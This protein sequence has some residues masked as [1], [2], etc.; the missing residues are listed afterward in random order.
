[1]QYIDLHSDYLYKIEK[2]GLNTI[3]QSNLNQLSKGNCLLNTYA[4]LFNRRD[5]KDLYSYYNK[6]IAIFKNFLKANSDLIGQVKSYNDIVQNKSNH[7]IS[8][9][10]SLEDCQILCESDNNIQR[11]YDDGVRL[12]GLLWSGENDIGYSYRDPEKP[13]KQ[14]GIELLRKMEDIGII[15][16][17]S[18]LSDKGLDDVIKFAQKP[19]L[20]SHSNTRALTNHHRNLTDEQIK[21]I[22][23]K[24]GI[25][26]INFYARY[27]DLKRI[28]EKSESKLSYI[29]SH[30][31][32]MINVGGGE[33]VAIGADF[34][35]VPIDSIFYS[36]IK[37]ASFMN[38][39]AERLVTEFGYELA[40]KILYKNA[41]N[42][43]KANLK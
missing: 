30:I 42:F 32:Q 2:N 20:A 27:I 4:I 41:L 40:E 18:H 22:G 24:G 3:F 37:D 5:I 35:G 31:H 6:I 36:E 11:L 34:D 7:K 33:V 19:F 9:L 16:D 10:L 43:F 21:K 12:G 38:F 8:A 15:A 39:F 13:L 17:I 26:G 28:D 29:F 14:F 23:D 1:M 25:I